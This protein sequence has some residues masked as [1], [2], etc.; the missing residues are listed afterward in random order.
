MGS[1]DCLEDSEQEIER[2]NFI[3]W[4]EYNMNIF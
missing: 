3:E 4:N 2:V 1:A